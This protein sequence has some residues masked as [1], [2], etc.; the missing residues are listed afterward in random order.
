MPVESLAAGESVAGYVVEALIGRGGMGEVY[1]AI[2]E[3]LGRP[4]AL[5]VL[6]A[7]VAS[8]DEASRRRLINES[9]WRRASTFRRRAGLR[10]R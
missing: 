7:G 2:D 5:K 1:R 3:R 9:A 10:G 8:D 6:T 4:V